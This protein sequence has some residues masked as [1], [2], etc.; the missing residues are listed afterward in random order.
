MTLRSQETN[1][2]GEQSGAPQTLQS[3]VAVRSRLAGIT[4]VEVGASPQ[5][6]VRTSYWRKPIPTAQYDWCAYEDGQEESG[7]Q[8]FGA[9]EFDAICGLFHEI[10]ERAS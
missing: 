4:S 8:G 1:G 5:I 2:A 3:G 10:E 7:V 9:T 6:R